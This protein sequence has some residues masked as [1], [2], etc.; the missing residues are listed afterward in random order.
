MNLGFGAAG[1]GLAILCA[2]CSGTESTPTPASGDPIGRYEPQTRI[3][4]DNVVSYG[5]AP[6]LRLPDP[7]KSGFRL[8]VPPMDLEPV[9]SASR[10]W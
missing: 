5:G 8:V 10:I 7:P 3:D 6:T 4:F 1:M 2:A 9:R